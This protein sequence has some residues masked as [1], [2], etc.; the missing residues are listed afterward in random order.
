MRKL[1]PSLFALSILFSSFNLQAEQANL[2]PKTNAPATEDAF[3]GKVIKNKVRVRLQPSYEGLVM[4]EL[5]K[6]DYVLA[7]GEA[8]EFLAIQPPEKTRGYVFRT[9]VL[10]GIIEGNRVNVRTKPDTDAPVIAQLNSGDKIQGTISPQNNKWYEVKLPSSA[11]FYVAKDYVEKVGDGNMYPRQMKRQEEVYN[12]LSTTDGVVQSELQKPF[13][14][15]NIEPIKANYKHIIYDF[16]DFPDAADKAKSALTA[17]EQ[18]YA[19]KKLSYL[20]HSNKS[21]AELEL[22]NQ[23]LAEELNSHKRKVE[24]LEEQL[25]ANQTVVM[26]PAVK[27]NSRLPVNMAEWLPQEEKL[28]MEWSEKSGEDNPGAYYQEQK[29]NSTVIKGILE[30]YSR[31]V[32]NKPGDYL[33]INTT[34]KLPIAYLYSTQINLKD[35]IGHEVEMRVTSRPNNNYAFPAYFVLSIE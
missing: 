34:T 21:S 4:G 12:L 1:S 24:T 8:D 15:I 30:S 16:T 20:E 2:Q 33:L 5:N 3:T 6:G 11:K 32:K 27:N 14:Q 23:K 17:V 10:D 18:V 35:L 25:R 9:F 31:P 29:S 26:N 28:F 13:N 22:K 7:R 19:Q